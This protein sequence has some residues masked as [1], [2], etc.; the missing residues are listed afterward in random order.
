M[1]IPTK[2][3][4]KMYPWLIA[5]T[6]NSNF[7]GRVSEMILTLDYREFDLNRIIGY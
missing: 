4:I 1:S 2:D 5:L 3:E 7:Q 6:D